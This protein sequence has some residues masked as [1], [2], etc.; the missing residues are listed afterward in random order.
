[1]RNRMMFLATLSLGVVTFSLVVS[2]Q[3]PARSATHRVS[4]QAR[5]PRTSRVTGRP[6]DDVAASARA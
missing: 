1:M 6:T 3:A 5:S 2:A 4:P